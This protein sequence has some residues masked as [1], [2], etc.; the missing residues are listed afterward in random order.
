L[1][2]KKNLGNDNIEIQK[3]TAPTSSG[4]LGTIERFKDFSNN[5]ANVDCHNN[6]YICGSFD[7]IQQGHIDILKQA[8]SLGSNVYVGILDDRTVTETHGS[9]FPILNLVERSLNV[10]AIRYVTDVI[11]GAPWPPS[12][13]LIKCLNISL[14]VE[15]KSLSKIEPTV[16]LNFDPYAEAKEL[17]I[18]KQITT[19]FDLTPMNL[20]N[21]IL[22]NR[23]LFIKKYAKKEG[24][25]H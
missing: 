23:E 19:N 11:V 10:L 2:K 6:V 25:S 14:V 3:F 22:N 12:K 18:Y 16:N 1:K 13:E 15:A 8:A 20:I 5:K 9:H 4:L 21:K 7:I 17:G 24:N